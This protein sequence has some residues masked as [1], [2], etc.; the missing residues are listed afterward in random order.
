MGRD[1]QGLIQV[2]L[3]PLCLNREAWGEGIKLIL[4]DLCTKL[5]TWCRGPWNKSVNGFRSKKKVH[6]RH[7]YLENGAKRALQELTGN[8]TPKCF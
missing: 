5:A 8:G 2:T 6:I 1:M 3:M 7:A 4:E